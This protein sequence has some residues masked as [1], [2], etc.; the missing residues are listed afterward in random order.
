MTVCQAALESAGKSISAVL[1]GASDELDLIGLS[2]RLQEAHD[3]LDAVTAPVEALR[4]ELAVLK[5]D[6][7]GRILAMTRAIH[8]ALDKRGAGEEA[9]WQTEVT[10]ASAE[11]L[12][13]LYRQACVRFRDTFPGNLRYLKAASAPLKDWSEFKCQ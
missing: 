8:I 7:A 4:T 11:E 10:D 9:L 5:A 13:R 12:L 6:L 1:E 2:D 3:T